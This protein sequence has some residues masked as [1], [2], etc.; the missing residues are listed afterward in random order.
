MKKIKTS[1]ELDS[2]EKH[3]IQETAKNL[4]G[5]AYSFRIENVELV[6]G[7][8]S[9][10]K[11]VTLSIDLLVKKG[12]VVKTEAKV[13][14]ELYARFQDFFPKPL[15]CDTY[16]GILI[17]P[18]YKNMVNLHDL[19][20]GNYDNEIKK[21]AFYR[22]YSILI[23][24]INEGTLKTGPTNPYS[25]YIERIKERINSWIENNNRIGPITSRELVDNKII[26]NGIEIQFNF[27]QLLEKIEK[28]IE[29]FSIFYKCIT[30][31]DAHPAN[32]L[33]DLNPPYN[34][35]FI[36][37][38]N[39]DLEGE[40]PIKDF[41]KVIHWLDVYAYLYEALKNVKSESEG[42]K[43]F[44]IKIKKSS[45]VIN[46]NYEI[47]VSQYSIMGELKRNFFDLVKQFMERHKDKNWKSRLYLSIARADLGAVP[48]QPF[49]SYEIILFCQGMM[50]LLKVCRRLHI[51]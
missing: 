17:T 37:L 30:P 21:A 39:C 28:N 11:R 40:D 4:F 9:K 1:L 46:I 23:N 31:G 35:L 7:I 36:D 12:R 5:P 16:E 20:M 13:L 25:I 45:N 2:Y 49:H 34:P 3:A 32:I 27:F 6:G 48:L 51:S 22:S 24:L 29:Q 38:P 43:I 8:A 18:Y 14:E 26:I 50:N 15:K 47:P 19:I 41:G 44:K 10:P 33:V 42:F